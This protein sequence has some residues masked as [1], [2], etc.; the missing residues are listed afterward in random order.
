[1]SELSSVEEAQYQNMANRR[2]TYDTLMWQTPVLSLTAQAFLFNIALD[3]TKGNFA[4]IGASALAIIVS[5]ASIQ[6]MAKHRCHEVKTSEWLHDFEEQHQ[7]YGLKPINPSEWAPKGK[8]PW[9]W[10]I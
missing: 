6:L 9:H 8:N 1:M 2:Q 3:L 10:L 5:F 4:Q 7:K